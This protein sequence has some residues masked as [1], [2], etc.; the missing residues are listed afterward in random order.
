MGCFCNFYFF[1]AASRSR[2]HL[3]PWVTGSAGPAGDLQVAAVGAAAS[4]WGPGGQS[5]ST[6]ERPLGQPS[7]PRPPVLFV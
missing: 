3:S 2:E 5:A 7:R 1:A 4:A 6:L